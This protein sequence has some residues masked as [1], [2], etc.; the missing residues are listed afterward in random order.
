MKWICRTVCLLINYYADLTGHPVALQHVYG[1]C[2]QH[3][4]DEKKC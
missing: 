4:A 1:V 2:N 3:T